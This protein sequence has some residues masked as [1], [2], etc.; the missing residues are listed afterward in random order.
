[1]WS[2]GRRRVHPTVYA[3][4]ACD[5]FHYDSQEIAASVTLRHHL[6]F[7]FVGVE[8]RHLKGLALQPLLEHPLFVSMGGEIAVDGFQYVVIIHL[9]AEF[10]E[11]SRRKQQMIEIARSGTRSTDGKNR[12]HILPADSRVRRC[13]RPTRRS[14]VEEI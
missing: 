8:P 7:D 2:V 3:L 14:K 10:G 6:L 13:L 1:M 9:G 12:L 4:P 5:F 11:A